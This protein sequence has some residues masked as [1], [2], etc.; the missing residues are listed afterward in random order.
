VSARRIGRLVIC[1]CVR[2]SPRE[3]VITATARGGE[4]LT[5]VGGRIGE[6]PHVCPTATPLPPGRRPGDPRNR[7]RPRGSRTVLRV[8]LTDGIREQAAAAQLEPEDWC[9]RVLDAATE[10]ICWMCGSADRCPCEGAPAYQD[11]E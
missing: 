6:V 8:P 1:H 10:R 5:V 4:E 7:G 11:P 3:C 2:S 9:E